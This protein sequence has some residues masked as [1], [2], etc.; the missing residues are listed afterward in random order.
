MA[1]KS[2]L[3]T[4]IR[5]LTE[6]LQGQFQRGRERK[7]QEEQ[8]KRQ[9]EGQRELLKLQDLFRRQKQA[10]LPTTEQAIGE[11]EGLLKPGFR[12]KVKTQLG[13]ITISGPRPVTPEQRRALEISEERLK[14]ARGREARA[15]KELPATAKAQG[16]INRALAK[17]ETFADVT[18]ADNITTLENSMA[19]FRKSKKKNLDVFIPNEFFSKLQT[20]V[21]DAVG[22]G[23]FNLQDTKELRR[24]STLK[25]NI[26]TNLE[27]IP[28]EQLQLLLEIFADI[29]D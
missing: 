2:G 20:A 18:L 16:N 15:E 5:T 13:D 19:A 14:I 17:F 22:K 26:Q 25:K 1:H 9:F 3:P 4:F 24:L 7:E 21:D 10:E 11:I 28:T 8:R 12:G 6:G 29:P 23:I 27:F